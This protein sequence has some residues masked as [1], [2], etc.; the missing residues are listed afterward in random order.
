MFKAGKWGR[1]H[2]KARMHKPSGSPDMF[3]TDAKPVARCRYLLASTI[4]FNESWA[5]VDFPIPIK[6][7]TINS[8]N[9]VELGKFHLQ[10]NKS[11]PGWRSQTT[12]SL[13][14]ATDG[15]IN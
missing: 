8:L 13:N 1:R 5:T 7:K 10:R 14:K 6:N 9:R 15:I 4:E 12:I 3:T 2:H 11:S